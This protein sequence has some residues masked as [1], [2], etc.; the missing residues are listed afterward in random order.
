MTHS[1][2]L[3]V[4]LS[5]CPSVRLSVGRSHLAFLAFSPLLPTRTRL[6]LVYTALLS[7]NPSV[8]RSTSIWLFVFLSLMSHDGPSTLQPF[9]SFLIRHSSFFKGSVRLSLGLYVGWLSRGWRNELLISCLS[10]CRYFGLAN[11][12]G[13]HLA[14]TRKPQLWQKF[15]QFVVVVGFGFG[16]S[17]DDFFSQKEETESQR[18]SLTKVLYSTR[19]WVTEEGTDQGKEN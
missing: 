16:K 11:W 17:A 13:N 3:S 2:R 15:G 5:V 12:K 7:I 9:F 10:D 18:S 1:V 8:L 19:E 6:R 4:R 14:E